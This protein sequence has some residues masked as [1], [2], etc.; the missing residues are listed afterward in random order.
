MAALCVQ[1]MFGVT[2]VAGQGD[3]IVVSENTEYSVC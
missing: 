1:H 2:A 3:A